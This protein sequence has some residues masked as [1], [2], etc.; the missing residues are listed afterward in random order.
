M[1]YVQIK[2][3]LGNQMFQYAF[4]RSKSI[5]NKEPLSLDLSWYESHSTKDTSRQYLLDKYNINVDVA[6]LPTLKSFNT[7]IQKLIRKII[8]RLSYKRDYIFQPGKLRSCSKYYEGNFPN[9]RYFKN[10]SEV[11]RADFALKNPLSA[12][13]KEIADIIVK[14]GGNR[15]ESIS[16]H[17]RRGDYVQNKYAAGSHGTLDGQYYDNAHQYLAQKIEPEKIAYFVFSDDIQWAR[18]NVFIDMNTTY[19]SNPD[20]RDYEELYLMS[21]CNHHI[22]ANSTFS[23]WGAWLNPK[24]SKIV[25]APKQWLKDT[26]YDTS[27]VCPPEWIRI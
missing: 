21:I 19:V 11:I 1:I 12:A 16:V 20:I 5:K 24:P 18:E 6:A 7:P 13:A 8:R 3:G 9:E 15:V 4:G 27:D 17:I 23:W 22:I 14:N 10:N 2:G 26:S 25:I